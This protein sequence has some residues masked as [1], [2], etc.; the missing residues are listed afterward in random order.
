MKL[1]SISSKINSLTLFERGWRPSVP[2]SEIYIFFNKQPVKK[3]PDFSKICNNIIEQTL[4]SLTLENKRKFKQLSVL[5]SDSSCLVGASILKVSRLTS[6]GRYD[7]KPPPPLLTSH[8]GTRTLVR[9]VNTFSTYT[10]ATMKWLG[11][12]LPPYQFWGF[13]LMTDKSWLMTDKCFAVRKCRASNLTRMRISLLQWFF[14]GN[15]LQKES[16]R[17]YSLL[18]TMYHYRRRFEGRS[19]QEKATCCV[20]VRM[21]SMKKVKK[22]SINIIIIKV[23]FCH[24]HNVRLTNPHPL[25]SNRR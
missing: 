9:F 20:V 19:K 24:N 22:E 1:R 17:E 18:I 6:I 2:V 13:W 14:A 25:T 23:S 21:V 8:R 7:L 10:Q 4:L 3:Q 15:K 11:R 16:I 12:T 5:G